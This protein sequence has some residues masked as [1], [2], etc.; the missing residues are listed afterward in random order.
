MNEAIKDIAL[1]ADPAA[2]LHQAA[3]DID[4]VLAKYR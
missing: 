2:R 3:K 1:G 4:D